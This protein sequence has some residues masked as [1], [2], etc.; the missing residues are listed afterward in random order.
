MKT[1]MFRRASMLLLVTLVISSCSVI[2][3][4]KV[5]A[6]VGESCGADSDC[7]GEG[8]ICDVSKRCASSCSASKAC[9]TG[10]VCG[11]DN[12][13]RSSLK[14]V[15][16]YNNDPGNPGFSKAHADGR[17]LAE[18]QL[19]G[20]QFIDAELA[21]FIGV[22]NA[23]KITTA[24]DEAVKRGANAIVMTS[25]ILRSEFKGLSQK[26]PNVKF[27][28]FDASQSV[29][30]NFVS[31]YGSYHQAWYIAGRTVAEFYERKSELV[32]VGTKNRC[33]G[34]LAPN[35]NPQ[36][37]VAQL[38]AFALGTV[39][40]SAGKPPIEIR[41][42]WY[43]SFA[44]PSD[45]VQADVDALV[46]VQGCSVIVNRLGVNHGNLQAALLGGA[47]GLLEGKVF[48]LA[49]DN[50]TACTQGGDV[51]LPQTCLGAPYWNFGPFY[52]RLFNDVVASSKTLSASIVENLKPVPSESM[53]GFK[54]GTA[55]G[56]EFANE[57]FVSS[58]RSEAVLDN[59]DVSFAT[60]ASA[61]ARW[62]SAFGAV[63]TAAKDPLPT[64]LN[65]LTNTY[66]MCWFHKSIVEQ[67][68]GSTDPAMDPPSSYCWNKLVVVPKSP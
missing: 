54:L 25:G 35:P 9:P 19:K 2:V 49:L 52:T 11:S 36:Q 46:K 32:P 30:D 41:V 37:I 13:C 31:F 57:A 26:Y 23:E 65:D 40:G 55:A 66:K 29:S 50:E 68:K 34:V 8:S 5:R 12:Y 24:V 44:P 17:K 63:D 60:V 42:R 45:K 3:D 10:S 21:P 39:K 51:R 1:L 62:W 6:G 20:V 4:S 14:V 56:L 53:F 7:Q 22:N 18:G 64:E 59:K 61:D 27:L 48:S 43:D 33:I 38:N 16:L 15:F 47:G 58:A 28:Q 67:T